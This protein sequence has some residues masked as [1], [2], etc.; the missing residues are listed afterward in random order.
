MIG[1]KVAIEVDDKE[2]V[3]EIVGDIHLDGDYFVLPVYI[4]HE[5]RLMNFACDER[6]KV[7]ERG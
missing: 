4:N 7:I 5:I 1:W 3:C 2:V 6:I